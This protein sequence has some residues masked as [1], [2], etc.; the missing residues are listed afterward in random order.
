MKKILF[1]LLIS[2]F[3]IFCVNAQAIDPV[4]A[5]LGPGQMAFSD[6]TYSANL[7]LEQKLRRFNPE[8]FEQKSNGK[9]V[10]DFSHLKGSP[11]EKN[12]FSFG[13]VTDEISNKSVNLYLRYNIYNDEIEL[14]ASL[15]P[16]EK[17]VALLKKYDISCTINGKYYKYAHF[18]DENNKTI[19]GY[20]IKIYSGK[21]VSLYKRLTSSFTPK[22]YPKNSFSQAEPATFETKATYYLQ[23]GNSITYLSN[24][25]K[26][27]LQEFKNNLAAKNILR[28][29]RSKLKKETDFLQ[30][31]KSLNTSIVYN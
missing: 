13:H 17:T 2:V 23:K 26:I 18:T 14:K 25:K 15:E 19:D 11:Y 20:I 8:L 21:K 16:N 24:K 9:Y 22:K 5:V 1:I 7:L 30:L 10:L 6:Y 3:S 27:L 31:V 29:K 28:K 4:A 12:T